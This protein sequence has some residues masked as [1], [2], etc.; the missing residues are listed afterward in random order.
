MNQQRIDWTL[1]MTMIREY[2]MVAVGAIALGLMAHAARADAPAQQPAWTSKNHYRV[3][4]SVDVGKRPRSH[5]PA[6]A[7]VDFQKLL[8]DGPS[9]DE[10]TI[11]VVPLDSEGR[12]KP[13]DGARRVPHRLDTL[14]GSTKG[15]LHF[16]VPDQTSTRFAVYFD[17]VASGLG[18]PRRYAGLVGDGDR[19]REGYKRRDIGAC[20]FD[21]FV[22]FDNDGDLDLF[23]GGV[24]PFVYCYENVGGNRLVD[25][26]RLSSDGESLT[27]PASS[28]NRSWLTVAFGDWDG[29][30]DQDLLPS[31]NDGPDR[32]TFVFY[33]NTTREKQGQLSFERVGLVTT[34]SGAPLAGGAQAGGWFPSVLLVDW[35]GDGRVDALVGS[36]NHCYFYRNLGAGEGGV[37]RLADAAPI[38]ADGQPITLVNPRFDCADVDGDGDLD[39]FA[40]TQPGPIHF[41]RNIGS[42]AKPVFAKSAPIAFTGKYLIGD[43]HSGLKVADFNG[44][45]LLDVAGGRF[46]ERSDLSDVQAPR[47][48]GEFY[49]N[50]GTLAE[51]RFERRAGAAGAPYTEQFPICDAVRQNCVR[52]VDWD[53]DGKT[54]LLA[55]DTD[56]FVWL[57]RNEAGNRFPVFATGQKLLAAGKPLALNASGGHARMDICDWN[58]D[59]IRDLIAADG[60]GTL[61]LF[62]GDKNGAGRALA[63]GAKVLVDGK[64]LQGDSRA[65]ALVCDWDNDEKKD[66]VF[67]DSKGYWLYKNVGT[68]AEPV[69]AAAQAIT[70]DGRPVRYVRPNV[71][72]FVDWDGD[73]RRDFIGCNFENSIRFYK[74][75]GSGGRGEEPRFDSPEGV[76]ILQASAPQMISGADA[77]DFNG[78]GDVDLLTGQGHG[79]SGLRYYERD[80]IEDELHGTHPEVTLGAFEAKPDTSRP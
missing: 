55:G 59:G 10:H 58:N 79:G 34:A 11:E 57:F 71:G 68:D 44:D 52:A 69:L 76:V 17:T 66:V 36:N 23:K 18:Q 38:E 41:F 7:E 39:L 12:P 4:L 28:D 46:W 74:N 53:D 64:P 15:T 6:A 42:R 24:E 62:L 47:E 73:G 54:D 72:S 25:R 49:A 63:A 5:S 35:D 8:G 27:L 48:Y 65:S 29:D 37:P 56:G 51:P 2:G 80:W 60:S 19:F 13:F 1:S 21:Q 61:T 70:F 40:G 30:G 78:D 77:V 45:R 20:H 9:F 50:V 22:D 75:L 3:L 32:G 43:A 16:V 33:R 67:A 26:G 31:F 14:L